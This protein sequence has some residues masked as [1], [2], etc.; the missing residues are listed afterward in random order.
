MSMSVVHI[1]IRDL[2]D[3]PG[4]GDVWDPVDVQGLY[5]AIPIP[6]ECGTLEIWIYSSVVATV[7]RM[8]PE[9]HLRRTIDIIILLWV[10]SGSTQ[11]R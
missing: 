3:F 5:R 8:S 2:V 7:R 11:M 4:V 1:T 10:F 9:T 6:T